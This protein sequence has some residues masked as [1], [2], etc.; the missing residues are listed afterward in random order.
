MIAVVKK[1]LLS[2]WLIRQNLEMLM[3]LCIPVFVGVDIAHDITGRGVTTE[4][5]LSEAVMTTANGLQISSAQQSPST[6]VNFFNS[7]P[8]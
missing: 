2:L 3:N 7:E 8:N 4:E 6:N 1:S 5:N